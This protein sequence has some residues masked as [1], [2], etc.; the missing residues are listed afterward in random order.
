V[1]VLAASAARHGATPN[2]EAARDATG[3][4]L[5]YLVAYALMNMGAFAVLF[6]W[7]MRATSRA[8]SRER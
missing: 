8:P 3:G 1:G 2:L 4:V 5:F 7:R 6:I